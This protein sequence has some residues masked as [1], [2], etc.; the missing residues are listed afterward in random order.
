MTAP[1]AALPNR[2]IKPL[3][4]LSALAALAVI[5]LLIVQFRVFQPADG[6]RATWVPNAADTHVSFMPGDS[7]RFYRFNADPADRTLLKLNSETPGFAF[8]AEVRN[9][10]GDMVAAFG[11]VLEQ[12]Q[13]ELAPAE[14]LY[15]VAVAPADATRSGT[16]TLS[17]GDTQAT[18][19][20]TNVAYVPV[21][22]PRCSVVNPNAADVL[23]RSAPADTFAMLGTLSTSTALPALG[24]T[25]DGWVAVN[26]AERQ[27]WLRGE[28]TALSGDCTTLPLLLNPTIPSA[29][30]DSAVYSLEVDRDGEGSFHEVISGPQ[31]DRSDLIWI[32]V[33]NL[34]TEPP[35]NFREFTLTLNCE[36]SA[37]D[38]VRWG[39]AYSPSLVCGQSVN[40]PF[41]HDASQQPFVVLLPEGSRQSYAQYTLS[42]TPA[43]G[44]G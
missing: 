26:Y 18:A 21:I 8:A 3:L 10:A 25:D 14:G 16:V 19:V 35:N 37:L 30:E 11:A 44:V 22:A 41:M 2:W 29:P 23:V 31:G 32:S 33:V 17:V 34:Y 36:G 6:T 42:V 28:V 7:E 27:G 38:A 5:A 40:A 4:L 24:R 20:R 39:S 13:I 12:V 9:N 1:Y 15:Q 43:G